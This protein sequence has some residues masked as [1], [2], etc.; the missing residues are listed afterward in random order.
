MVLN[1]H[2]PLVGPAIVAIVA[3][4][5][6]FERGQEGWDFHH[7]PLK[8]HLLFGHLLAA[9]KMGAGSQRGSVHVEIKFHTN[10]KVGMLGMGKTSQDASGEVKFRRDPLQY[11]IMI[12]MVTVTGMGSILVVFWDRPNFERWSSIH[13]GMW[14]NKFHVVILEIMIRKTEIYGC[15]QKYW[16]PQIIHF[17]RVFH[18]KPSILGYHYLWKYPYTQESFEIFH[19]LLD[20]GWTSWILCRD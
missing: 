5:C 1:H 18:Y 10:L 3:C 17:N 9:V 16:Y 20:D 4:I 12:L 13:L 2:C 11:Y 7:R 6:C 15:F 14:K 19:Q 8:T